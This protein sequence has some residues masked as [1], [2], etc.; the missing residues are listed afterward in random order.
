MVYPGAHARTSPDKP[1]V[2][3]A[4]SGARMTYA[5]LD[6]G[7]TRLARLLR[8]HGLRPGDAV[9]LLAENHLRFME[10][11]WA[12]RRSGLYLTAINRHLSPAEAAYILNDAGA[13]AIVTTGALAPTAVAAVAAAPG[14]VHRFVVDGAADGFEPYDDAVAAQPATPLDEQPRGGLMLYSSGTTGRP[15]G[16]RR[17]LSG[18]TVDDP[19]D[20]GTSILARHLFGM[21]ETSIYLC[22]TPLYHSAGIQWSTGVHELGATLVLMEKFD[23]EG[24][25]EVIERERVTHTQVVPT[26]LVR[27]LKLPGERRLRH[28]LSSLRRLI[29]SAGPCPPDVKRQVIDWLGPIVD[30]YYASTEGAGISYISAADWLKHPGSV[31]QM[32]N[33]IAHVCD[34]EGA[35]LPAGQPGLLYFEQPDAPF[36]Y[37]GDPEKTAASRHPDHPNWTAVGDIGRLDDE[38]YLYLTDRKSF[39]IISGGVN[40]Y[41]AEVEACLVMHPKVADVAV[42]GLPDAEMGEFVQAVVAPA[43]G[44]EANEELADELHR[45]A[46]DNLAHYKVPRVFSFRDELPRMATG[47]LAKGQLR[48]EYLKEVS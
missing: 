2:I 29:H 5:E 39:M 32:L 20:V 34:D 28:D 36:S 18:R 3:M 6:A 45:Y 14:C 23:A 42:F 27:V 15:K 26:M 46:R 44:V 47:K 33:G 37:H 48:D 21:D 9:A 43:P 22:P 19:K 31:G 16:V 40:I 10:V 4:G 25:L 17:P 13:K 35:E 11:V 7:S 12:A 38:G 41:P 24:L 8:E 30:E 1:A